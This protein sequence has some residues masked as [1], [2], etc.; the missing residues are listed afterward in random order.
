MN[1]NILIATPEKDE[2]FFIFE[3]ISL[4]DQVRGLHKLRNTNR[5]RGLVFELR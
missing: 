1:D 3:E 5:G 4:F 2:T